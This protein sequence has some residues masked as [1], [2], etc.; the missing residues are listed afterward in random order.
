LAVSY[1]D[2]SEVLRAQGDLAG[3]LAAAQQLKERM[4]RLATQ[5]P[6][7]ASWQRD[8]S[9]SY[10]M[11][12]DVQ[13]AQGD[14]A[15][16]LKSYRESLGI[17]EKLAKQDPSNALWQS[18]LAL[19]HWR[20]GSAWAKIEPGSRNEARAMVE[21]GR[22]LLR[23]LKDRVGLSADQQGWLTSMEADL[24]KMQEKD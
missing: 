16:A 9:F 7:N 11:I 24:Q 3:A 14:L 10:A 17:R 12:G 1:S 19:I 21:K 23:Q 6:G 18:D 4:E 22:D 20:T 5:D 15:G 2:I 8:L 13:S